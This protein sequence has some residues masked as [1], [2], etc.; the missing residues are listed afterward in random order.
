M[1]LSIEAVH[2]LPRRSRDAPVRRPHPPELACDRHSMTTIHKEMHGSVQKS[3]GMQKVDWAA[4]S[5]NMPLGMDD[6]SVETRK[7]FFSV[8]DING[9]GMVSL[10]E[11][12]RGLRT[13]IG[14][15]T[16]SCPSGT[17]VQHV[18]TTT[19]RSASGRGQK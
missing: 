13:F 17:V 18:T 3:R 4:F 2:F 15:G 11:Y 6:A 19:R 8:C 1:H 5:K 14:A 12:D 16:L 9:N 10:A 7:K